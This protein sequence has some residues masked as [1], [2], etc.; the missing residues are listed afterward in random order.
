[1]SPTNDQQSPPTSR[2]ILKLRSKGDTVRELQTLLNKNGAGMAVDG[3]FGS[4]TQAARAPRRRRSGSGHLECAAHR[5]PV[6]GGPD[7]P[8]APDAPGAVR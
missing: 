7:P 6:G 2:P 1:M 4:H 8:D 5:R 3:D